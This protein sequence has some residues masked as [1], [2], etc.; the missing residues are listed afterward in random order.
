[1]CNHAYN[2]HGDYNTQFADEVDRLF[3]VYLY[4]SNGA[5]NPQEWRLVKV[6][7][8][9]EVF[10]DQ[11]G[12]RPPEA[13]LDRLASFILKED[14]KRKKGVKVPEA[15]EYPHLS[16]RQIRTRHETEADWSYAEYVDIDGNNRS[17]ETRTSRIHNELRRGQV[18]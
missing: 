16:D 9:T 14:L 15:L 2:F 17:E 6:A 8:I 4:D 13:Q 5:L 3:D 10:I 7:E 18:K 11:T 1:M 12:E